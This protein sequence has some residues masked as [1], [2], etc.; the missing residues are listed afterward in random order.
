M[1][2]IKACVRTQPTRKKRRAYDPAQQQGR[3]IFRRRLISSFCTK[4]VT[5][6]SARSNGCGETSALL[7]GRSPISVNDH[8]EK[9]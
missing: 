7:S 5:G 3:T 8:G 4:A 9:L 1:G 2:Y 6:Q